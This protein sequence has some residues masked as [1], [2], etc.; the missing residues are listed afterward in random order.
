MARYIRRQ[1]DSI[2]AVQWFK[3][4]D[5]PEVIKPSNPYCSFGWLLTSINWEIIYPGDYIIKYD[6]GEYSVWAQRKFEATFKKPE[7]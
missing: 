3:H 7:Q 2:E 4:G 6:N 5:H 1:T